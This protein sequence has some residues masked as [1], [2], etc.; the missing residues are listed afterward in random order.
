[1]MIHKLP[2][3]RLQLVVETQLN[4]QSNQNSVKIPKVVSQRI[5]KC[6][7]KTLGTSVKT[8]KC[9]LPP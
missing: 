7:Y 5:R 2:F 3:C 8:A 4:K 6:Y 9:P 1:M